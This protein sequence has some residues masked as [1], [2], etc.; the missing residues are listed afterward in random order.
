MLNEFFGYGTYFMVF[1]F[2]FFAF[3]FAFAFTF[4]FGIKI[5]ISIHIRIR[6]RTRKHKTPAKHVHFEK[7]P[8]KTPGRKT[9]LQQSKH[10]QNKHETHTRA[11]DHH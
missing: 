6:T 10:P 5:R 1:T 9:T 3:A 7:L 4:A 8:A 2:R 11:R